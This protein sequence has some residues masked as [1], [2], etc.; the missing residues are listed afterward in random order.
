MVK[1]VKLKK[2]NVFQRGMSYKIQISNITCWICGHHSSDYAEY[3]LVGCVIQSEIKSLPPS[4]SGFLLGLLFI[5]KDRRDILG[6]LETTHHYNPDD[7][8]LQQYYMFNYMKT[9]H[10]L[11]L[12]L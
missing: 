6:S 8:V 12:P 9:K 10:D 1:T 2:F 11:L 4:S 5:P 7:C 3:D